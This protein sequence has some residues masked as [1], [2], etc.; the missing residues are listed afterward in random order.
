MYN[1]YNQDCKEL[2][3]IFGNNVPHLGTKV[4]CRMPSLVSISQEA[5]GIETS[6]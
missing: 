1:W 3:L 4:Q 2:K 5:V 6:A